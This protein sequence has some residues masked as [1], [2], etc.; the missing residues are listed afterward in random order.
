MNQY[1]YVGHGGKGELNISGGGTV[2]AYH[3][4]INSRSFVAIEVGTGSNMVLDNGIGTI[5]NNGMVRILAS[6]SPATNA[7]YAP[8][9]ARTWTGTGVYQA[10]GGKWDAVSHVFTVSGVQ[11][12]E[13]G[14]EFAIDRL[15]TQR[16]LV[17]DTN[18]PWK[19]GAS[20]VATAVST[21]LTFTATAIEGSTLNKLKGML[22]AGDSL[23][24]G[25]NLT[26]ATGY[27]AGDPVYLSFGNGIGGY[28]EDK[29]QIWSYD[30]TTWAKLAADDLTY[31][32]TYASFTTTA[33]G[34]FAVSV[35]EPGMGVL[36]LGGL[37]GTWVLRRRKKLMG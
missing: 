29:L 4:S 34:T 19:L 21:P 30:G 25:W 12:G 37:V 5:L 31:D 28:A 11:A 7:I 14:E 9:S 16:V 3:A 2:S 27:A 15:D 22:G 6:A 18:S 10:V 23:L 33:M 1:L 26:A 24:G 13:S 35:P 8:I 17:D 32:G 20:F 36:L